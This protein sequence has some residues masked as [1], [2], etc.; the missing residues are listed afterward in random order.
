MNSNVKALIDSNIKTAKD[1]ELDKFDDLNA[2]SGFEHNCIL[3][4]G[5]EHD[6]I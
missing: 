3:I 5:L 6:I 4:F 1:S 2:L